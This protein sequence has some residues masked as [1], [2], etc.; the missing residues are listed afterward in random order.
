ML[1]AH[2]WLGSRQSGQGLVALTGQQKSLQVVT[3]AASLGERAKQV[4]KL[5]RIVFER[6]GGQGMRWDMV[7]CEHLHLNCPMSFDHN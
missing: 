2:N 1:G 7:C 4:V 3:K 5:H 6:A